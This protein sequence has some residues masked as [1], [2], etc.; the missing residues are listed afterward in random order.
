MLSADKVLEG[1]RNKFLEKYPD[2]S[3]AAHS[4]SQCHF[5]LVIEA[6]L[7]DRYARIVFLKSD[8]TNRTTDDLIDSGF[9]RLSEAIEGVATSGV[10]I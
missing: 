10:V 7:R 4:P 5:E 6:G 3:F 2:A 1:I 9:K 8:L